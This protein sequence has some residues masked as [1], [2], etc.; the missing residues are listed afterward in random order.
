MRCRAVGAALRIEPAAIDLDVGLDEVVHVDVRVFAMTGAGEIDVTADARLSIS[1]VALGE[2]AGARFTSHGRTGGHATIA[3]S[4]R[5]VTGEASVHV[6]IHSAR[7]EDSA[8]PDAMRWLAAATD[9]MVDATLEPGDGAVLPPNLGRLDVDFAATDS[10]D[11]H[12]VALTGPDLDVRVVV[13][14]APGPRHVELT[15]AEWDA[16]ARTSV[17][18][19]AQLTV[20]SLSSSTPTVARVATARLSISDLPFAQEVLR[21]AAR[22]HER[23][24]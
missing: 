7:R 21:G 6:R 10:D 8:P 18:G 12:E 4:L 9:V 5:E 20:R 2:L 23:P 19:E 3:A 22:A 15:A 14:G 17:R 1:G 13:G 11:V 24:R 16:V